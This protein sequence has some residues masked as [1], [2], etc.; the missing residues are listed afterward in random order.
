MKAEFGVSRDEQDLS[1]YRWQEEPFV[2]LAYDLYW[3][4]NSP[5]AGRFRLTPTE[6]RQLA[7]FLVRLADEIDHP[8]SGYQQEVAAR[9][10][11]G[12]SYA[13]IGRSS[14]VSREAVRR[15]AQRGTAGRQPDPRKAGR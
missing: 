4:D 7:K 3:L 10:A 5:C 11:A 9:H 8:A 12:E 6:A 1:I 2:S 14:G 15:A 13:S